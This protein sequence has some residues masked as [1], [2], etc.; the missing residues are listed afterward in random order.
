MRQKVKKINYI[1]TQVLKFDGQLAQNKII[2]CYFYS[3][4]TI[5]GHFVHF[6]LEEKGRKM[7]CDCCGIL[8]LRQS[9]RRVL[10]WPLGF[11]AEGCHSRL[12]INRRKCLTPS[13]SSQ[14]DSAARCFLSP[15]PL[16]ISHTIFAPTIPPLTTKTSSIWKRHPLTTHPPPIL[17]RR[18]PTS[19]GL[20]TTAPSRMAWTLA[21]IR[22]SL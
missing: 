8:E 15:E 5:N 2:R 13:P 18:T 11:K 14:G 22:W 20:C 21:F 9:R 7:W 19:K 3:L 4:V 1:F 10:S 16:S 12:R 17:L 6:T